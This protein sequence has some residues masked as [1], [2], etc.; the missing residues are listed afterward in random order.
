MFPATTQ[1]SKDAPKEERRRVPSY[2][3]S[4]QGHPNKEGKEGGE[5]EGKEKEEDRC[6][7]LRTSVQGH[8]RE[9]GEPEYYIQEHTK[10]RRGKRRGGWRK[11]LGSRQTPKSLEQASAAAAAYAVPKWLAALTATVT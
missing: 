9:G 2:D 10:R 5:R 1:A 7:Q 3:E 4:I 11:G 8:T 6:S